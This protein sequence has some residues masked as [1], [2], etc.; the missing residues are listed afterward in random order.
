MNQLALAALPVREHRLRQ[1]ALRDRNAIALRDVANATATH[2]LAHGF[3]D[4]VAITAQKS[5]A[6]AD[7]L[8]LAG[9]APVDNLLQHLQLALPSD[10][11]RSNIT[12]RAPGVRLRT[13]SCITSSRA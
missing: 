11:E 1:T 7:R 6:I 10:V 3:A 4:L 12:R 13:S 2:R 5:I 9:K 8:V